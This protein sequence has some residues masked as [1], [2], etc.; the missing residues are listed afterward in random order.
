MHTAV[1]IAAAVQA[2]PAIAQAIAAP[3]H[4]AFPA[5][6]LRG[7]LMI[8]QAPEVLLNNR[9]DRLAPGAR[10]R[11]VDNLQ[12]MPAA[13]AG[14]RLTVHYTREP[15]TGLLMDI[16]ILNATERARQLWPQSEREAQSWLFDAATQTWKRP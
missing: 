14:Q 12:Q 6:A 8:G 10:I 3:A 1:L 16:W 9:P 7:E 11:G 2:N 13:L 4:R 5:Q 15:A